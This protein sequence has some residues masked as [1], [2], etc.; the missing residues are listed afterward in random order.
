G[1]I[2][3]DPE[4]PAGLEAQRRA[5]A[6]EKKA[7]LVAPYEEAKQI[8]LSEAREFPVKRAKAIAAAYAVQNDVPKK[9]Q[10]S[11]YRCFG[12]LTR[13]KGSD[14]PIR[15]VMEWCLQQYGND[16]ESF[17][18]EHSKYDYFAVME[19]FSRWDGSHA[20]TEAFIKAGM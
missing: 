6:A 20:Q 8:S 4:E 10:G 9:D 17:M 19:Q 2:P 7:A 16:R 15:Q 14:L 11:F 13:T 18:A 12:H 1:L 5:A 3:P